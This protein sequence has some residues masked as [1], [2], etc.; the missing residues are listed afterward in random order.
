MA[1][2]GRVDDLSLCFNVFS[3]NDAAT[4]NYIAVKNDWSDLDEKIN[5]YLEHQDEAE[6][7]GEEMRRTLRN[8][9]MTPAAEACYIRRMIYEF[10]KVQQFEPKLYKEVKDDDGV[11]HEKMRGYS[12]ERFVFRK[13][14]PFDI[15]PPPDDYFFKSNQIDFED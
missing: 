7:I 11:T 4:Q 2:F 6:Q 3:A 5:Y 15:P 12:W 10:A 8:R 14:A 1:T 9:Y 13:P